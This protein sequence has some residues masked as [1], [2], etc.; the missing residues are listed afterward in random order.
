LSPFQ[1]SSVSP[2]ALALKKNRET[3]S[4]NLRPLP[5]LIGIAVSL[6]SLSPALAMRYH[7]FQG[8]GP[9]YVPF[10]DAVVERAIAPPAARA[11]LASSLPGRLRWN[12][13]GTPKMLFNDRGWLS[14]PS[15]EAPEQVARSFLRQHA[16]LFGLS[17][18]G[19]AAMET[20]RVSPLH[21][22]PQFLEMMQGKPVSKTEVPHVVLLRQTFG[23]LPAAGR[24]GLVTIGVGRDGRV[25]FVGSSLAPEAAMSGSF[26]LS[27]L[28]ALS[29]AA[30]DV[31]ML[32]GTLSL[33]TPFPEGFSTYA[34][35]LLSDV[36]RVR[37]RALPVPGVGVRPVFEVTLLDSSHERGHPQAFIIHLD[38]ETGRVWTRDNQVQHLSDGQGGHQ[39]AALRDLDVPRAPSFNQ[40]MGETPAGAC[41]APHNF[42]V[43]GDDNGQIV[44]AA[45]ATT[46]EDDDI[47]IRLSYA[48][49][50]VAEQDLLTS[51]EL[52]L[53]TPAGG[54]PAGDYQVEI[55][56]FNGTA[57]PAIAY[58]GAFLASPSPAGAANPLALPSW[59]VFPV[60]P[61]PEVNAP[62]GTNLSED[63]REL[64]CWRIA[65]GDPRDDN[66]LGGS[67]DLCDVEVANT[68]SRTPW[69]ALSIGLPTFT[70][71]GNNASTA[72]SNVNFVAPDTVAIRPVALDRQ[73]NFDWTNSWY[74]SGCNPLSFVDPRAN[75]ADFEAATVNLFVQHN[76]VHDWAYLLGWTEVNSTLQFDN[77]G[78]TGPTR[79]NDGEVGSA[80]AGRLTING[81]DNANQLTLQD[82][83]P[84]ITN[85]YLW[86]PLPAAIYAPCVD[87]AYDLGIIVHE[88]THAT[89]NRMTGGP[90]GALGGGQA[91]KMGEAWSDLAAVEFI[92]GNDLD[93]PGT[94][95]PFAVAAYATGN[96]ESGIRSY[97]IA[98]SPLTYGS[99]EYDPSGLTSPHADSEIWGATQYTVRQLLVEKFDAAFPSGDGKLQRD[100]A[101]GVRA[102]TECPGN[103]RWAHL[104]YDGLLLQP[105]G[106][107]M[108]DARDAML[109]ADLLRY[110][111]E[112][113]ALMWDGFAQ[114]GMGFSASTTG[115]ADANPIPAYDSP[116]R[117][118]PAVITFA[119]TGSD[120]GSPLAT[121]YVG[122]FEA[123]ATPSASLNPEVEAP[124]TLSFVPGTYRFFV[125]APGYGLQRFTETFVAGETRTLSFPLR[126]N[127]A[128]SARGAV[129]SGDGDSDADRANLIDE[130]E[131]TTWSSTS[132]VGTASEGK[133]E[134]EFVAGRQVTVALSEAVSI[135][136]VQLSA[137]LQ[138]GQSRF[139]AL[140][141]FD[142]Q[143]CNNT[144]ADCSTDEGFSTFFQSPDDAFPGNA[145]RPTVAALNLRSF[146][147][148]TTDATHVRVV[149]RK[150]QCTGNPF[151]QRER[152][153]DH[154]D[155]FN[156]PDCD[157]GVNLQL[158]ALANGMRSPVPNQVRINELQVFGKPLNGLSGDPQ[159]VDGLAPGAGRISQGGALGS[160]VLLLAALALLARRRRAH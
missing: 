122:D 111:G 28:A 79:A 131:N 39:E 66:E 144:A 19:I 70:T 129:A 22:S 33:T 81:R 35:D 104:L 43:T 11:A 26:A 125:Q 7:E 1:P 49:S 100:C 77:F 118:D 113:L 147:V 130:T 13:H 63:T 146:E 126:A 23:G 4:M 151:Y 57:A 41:G 84:G 16:A 119:A 135:D 121:I 101:T 148:P 50:V 15:S 85:Q 110:N 56:P 105:T 58:R 37:R 106:T 65:G 92:I 2:R 140:L 93:P 99:M 17:E 64:W 61:I 109:A 143:A 142:L 138:P 52:M 73:Y 128:A 88:V 60:S 112:N 10:L 132:A 102:S 139:S 159:N 30:A 34:S 62:P 127:Y 53:Y 103:R 149:V 36:Q 98:N 47:T 108:L 6:S 75:L 72:V 18:S 8:E 32:L 45:Q 68:A 27:E 71:H 90:D 152:F 74:E 14:A 117:S 76:R 51:P 54:V 156:D 83:I 107:T 87:G 55:C 158:L 123:R 80:Q 42:A 59:K 141:S 155:P 40:F 120:G 48:G 46:L 97:S 24:E 44:I 31:G 29:A 5:V 94:D 145:L 9:G 20:L 150:S 136:T 86:Q 137:L 160:G 115:A 133:G 114:R 96:T 157:T 3:R 91:G 25:G 124:R 89:S 134:G 38:A 153:P 69:D 116:L 21:E 154:G 12:H 82:G 78:N 67:P 95:N